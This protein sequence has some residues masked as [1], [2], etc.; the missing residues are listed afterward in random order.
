MRYF[1]WKLESA[2]VGIS[3]EAMYQSLQLHVSV[4]SKFVHVSVVSQ[5]LSA[6]SEHSLISIRINES[7]YASSTYRLMKG[8]QVYFSK[9]NSKPWH[10]FASSVSSYPFSQVHVYPPA[11]VL[12]HES[13]SPHISSFSVHSSISLQN[14]LRNKYNQQKS[15]KLKLSIPFHQKYL[16]VTKT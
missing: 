11:G 7:Q 3:G 6:S 8:E 13:N 12:V 14:E 10:A 2:L 16:N 5:L 9:T 15:E 1:R 4:P